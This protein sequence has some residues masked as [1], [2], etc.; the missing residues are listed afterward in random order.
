MEPRETGIHGLLGQ[1]V[2]HHVEMETKEEAWRDNVI[3][4]N[5]LMVEMIV[6]E[7]AQKMTL[8]SVIQ[9]L[10]QVNN[11]LSSSGSRPCPRQLQKT[12][13]CAI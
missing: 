12:N 10:V 4:L 5:L 8:R 7:M 13:D 11:L 2:Q 6:R 1:T 9:M 3:I